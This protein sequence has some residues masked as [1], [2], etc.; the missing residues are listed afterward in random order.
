MDEKKQPSTLFSLIVPTLGRVGE[1]GSFLDSITGQKLE[2]FT[3]ADVEVIV[4]DQNEDG[5]LDAMLKDYGTRLS[6]KHLKIQP[7]GLSNA[8]NAGLAV[9][10]GRI[11]AFPDD[12][13]FYADDTLEK[14]RGFFKET[15]DGSGLF[16]RAVDPKTREDFLD[17][18]KVEKIV[19]SP[20][21]S[22][23]FWGSSI[24]QFYPREAVQAVGP[25]DERFGIG[26][27]W[28]SGEETDYAIRVLKKGFPIHFRP[29][30]VVFHEKVN[31]LTLRNIPKEKVRAYSKG[32]GATC[33]KHGFGFHLFL[34]AAKQA[35]GVFLYAMKLDFHKSTM[36]WITATSR[37]RGFLEYREE[38]KRDGA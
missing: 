26:G 25:F 35:A 34:K 31:P 6:L 10:G 38:G 19:K 16:I 7:K 36:C 9:V 32:F 2:S 12:D 15:G 33:R 18:P 11:V 14:V 22:S 30:I 17:Y 28:G 27:I 4:V 8:R 5:R 1:L 13:C 29:E 23:V 3:L 37:L 21:D 24:S 20:G